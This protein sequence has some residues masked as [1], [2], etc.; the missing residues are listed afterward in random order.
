MKTVAD[1]ICEAARLQSENNELRECFDK[2]QEENKRLANRVNQFQSIAN[3]AMDAQGVSFD[4]E[5]RRVEV[6]VDMIVKVA[7]RRTI[8]VP[9]VISEEQ[10]MN[11]AKAIRDN[12]SLSDYS[13]YDVD[14]SFASFE[15]LPDD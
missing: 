4:S 1:H 3:Q 9:S 5:E 12:L 2:L 7:F 15:F 14:S 11:V 8:K 10:M 13:S 6:S